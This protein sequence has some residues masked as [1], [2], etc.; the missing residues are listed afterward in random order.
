MS[1][2]A[3]AAAWAPRAG[4][5]VLAA[6][7]LIGPLWAP[8]GFSWIR[9]T[10]S[11]QAGQGQA[12]AWIIRTGFAAY[13]LGVLVAA[14]SDRH[15]RPPVRAALAM[16]GLGLL[17]AALWSNAPVAP[18]LPADPREDWLHSVASGVVGTAFAWPAPPGSPGAAATGWPGPDCWSPSR[19][20]C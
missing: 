20:R 2:A 5:A 11:E 18:G 10:T 1:R 19:C 4:I 13:G 16:F 15:G 7:I 9:H 6:A 14:G 12:G 8:E 17:A 3:A